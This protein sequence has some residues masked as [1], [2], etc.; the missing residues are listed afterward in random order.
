MS[1]NNDWA[2]NFSN[3]PLNLNLHPQGQLNNQ[4]YQQNAYQQA[5]QQPNLNYNVNPQAYSNPNLLN[6]F[7]PPPQPKIN[8]TEDNEHHYFTIELPQFSAQD[9]QVSV[10]G[11]RLTILAS[12]SN[13]VSEVSSKLHTSEQAQ[14]TQPAQASTEAAQA[15]VEEPKP[16]T[17]SS[18]PA[19]SQ[20]QFNTLG[21]QSQ[22]TST[23]QPLPF[24]YGFRVPSHRVSLN[25]IQASFEKNVLKIRFNKIPADQQAQPRYIQILTNKL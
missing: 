8:W 7:V 2:K 25:D 17:A 15:A 5:G 9:V 24:Q 6:Q 3:N 13:K 12:K 20:G 4:S 23:D 22:S 16:S 1:Q 11:E 18:A 14:P 21:Q 19:N 10:L